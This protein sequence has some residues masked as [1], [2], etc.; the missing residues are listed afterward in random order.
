[1]LAVD[2]EIVLAAQPEVP[3]PRR[4]RDRRIQARRCRLVLGPG[5]SGHGPM[6][7]LPPRGYARIADSPGD[8]GTAKGGKSR[9]VDRTDRC[10]AL[11]RRFLQVAAA[12]IQSQVGAMDQEHRDH[13]AVI[14]PPEDHVLAGQVR[15]RSGD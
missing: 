4:M 15:S 9:S 1:E 3:D 8:Q 2:R 13:A 5:L 7:T 11:S 14:M 10:S 12:M 6:P